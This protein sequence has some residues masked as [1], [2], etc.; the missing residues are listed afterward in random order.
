M[1]ALVFRTQIFSEVKLKETQL[2][3]QIAVHM[4]FD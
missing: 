1:E 2:Y 4:Q 3:F